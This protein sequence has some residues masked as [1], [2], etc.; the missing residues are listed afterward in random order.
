MN[1]TGQQKQLKPLNKMKQRLFA[2]L[3]PLTLCLFATEASANDDEVNGIYY[4]FKGSEATVTYLLNGTNNTPAYTGD[5]VIPEYVSYKGVTYRVTAVGHW[6]FQYC[7]NMTSVSL[8]SSVTSL[9]NYAFY[10][11][12]NLMSYEIPNSIT[13]VG[14]YAFSECSGLESISIPSS[15]TS[16]GI[17]AFQNCT[18]LTSVTLPSSVTAV[19][20]YTFTGCSGLRDVSLPNSVTSIGVKAFE[21]CTSLA[22]LTLPESVTSIENDAFNG[23][24]SLASVDI[25]SSVK[26]VDHVRPPRMLY[27]TKSTQCMPPMPARKGTKVRINGKKRPKKMARL[28]HLSKNASDLAK[29]SLFS[30]AFCSATNCA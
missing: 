19:S 9:G 6:A 4:I 8:P 22:S 5:V 15:V 30:A 21:K 23:C 13:T 2:L 11:C 26:S 29:A 27:L 7:T 3:L 24:T 20:N 18:S 14:M 16:I 10:H 25:P 1:K 17:Y 28:P 12:E